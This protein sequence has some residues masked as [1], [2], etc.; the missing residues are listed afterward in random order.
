MMT[1]VATSHISHQQTIGVGQP[2]LFGLVTC[3]FKKFGFGPF[4]SFKTIFFLILTIYTVV[5][6]LEAQVCVPVL[7][8]LNEEP[9]SNVRF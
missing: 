3:V 5:D 4:W 8:S 1:S 9:C 6:R 2:V 7:P